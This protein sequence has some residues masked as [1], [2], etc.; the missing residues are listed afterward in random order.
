MKQTVLALVTLGLAVSA[1][2]P[3]KGQTNAAAG[4]PMPAFFAF[5]KLKSLAG[6]WEGTVDEKDSGPK[7]SVSYRVTSN[8]S[9]LIETQFPGTKHEMVTVYHLDGPQVVMT[10]YCAMGNQPRMTMTSASS[11]SEFVFDYSG[12]TNVDPQKDMH[13]HSLRIRFEGP[14]TIVS[15][16]QLYKEGKK[17]ASNR[18]F[19]T[20]KG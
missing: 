14:N 7:V 18:F 12:G 6:Q 9:A 11:A 10:H 5:Q 20:R 17:A 16:W 15:E 3:A 2:I 13:M 19:L 1:V 8:G 4:G